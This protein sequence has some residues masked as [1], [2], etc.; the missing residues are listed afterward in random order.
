MRCIFSVRVRLV[1]WETFHDGAPAEASA[2]RVHARTYREAHLGTRRMGGPPTCVFFL[3]FL[4]PSLVSLSSRCHSQAS[5]A[6]ELPGAPPP[7]ESADPAA[8]GQ[9]C[10]NPCHPSSTC[11]AGATT[12]H[13]I[14]ANV[15]AFSIPA[16]SSRQRSLQLLPSPRSSHQRSF[17]KVSWRKLFFHTD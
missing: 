16:C 13:A 17:L 7:W 8:L 10:T 11:L 2:G 5:P 3:L 9:I 4:F 15:E 12:D 6:G 1:L 14:A